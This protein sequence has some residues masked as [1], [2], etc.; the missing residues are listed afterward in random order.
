MNG[1]WVL[2][3][4]YDHEFWPTSTYSHQIPPAPFSRMLLCPCHIQTLWCYQF[5]T[6]YQLVL[7]SRQSPQVGFAPFFPFNNFFCHFSRFSFL[8]YSDKWDFCFMDD[9]DDFTAYFPSVYY[10]GNLFTVCLLKSLLIHFP[11]VF[12][13]NIR[14]CFKKNSHQLSDSSFHCDYHIEEICMTSI[15]IFSIFMFLFEI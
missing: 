9:F 1:H 13:L 11:L 8:H 3:H 4:L 5:E 6:A 10:F 14:I 15:F 2:V 7:Q 12:Y